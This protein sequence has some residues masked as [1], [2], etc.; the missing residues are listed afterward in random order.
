[1]VVDYSAAAKRDLSAIHAY[2]AADA[3]AAADA[4]IRK[5]LDAADLA[6]TNPR[7]GRVVPE[8]GN[9][10]VR[11]VFVRRYRIVYRVEARRILVLRVIEGSMVLR[12]NPRGKRRA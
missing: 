3:A 1:V 9:A 6:A 2:I 8:W 11:E 5:L 4:W 12:R 10:G 7:A